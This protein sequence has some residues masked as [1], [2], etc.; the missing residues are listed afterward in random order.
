MTEQSSLPAKEYRCDN[1]CVTFQCEELQLVHE[2]AEA[3]P[4]ITYS[5]VGLEIAPTTG[6]LHLQ[7]Y[8]EFKN[9]MRYSTFASRFKNFKLGYF[10]ARF[11]TQAKAINYCKK[12]EKFHE[13]GEPKHQGERTDLA[14]IVDEIKNGVSEREL[15]LKYVNSFAKHMKWVQ[16]MI[17]LHGHPVAKAEYNLAECCM[18]LQVDDIPFENPQWNA[19]AVVIG[20]PGIGKTEFALA[21]F[22]N[23]LIVSHV[24]KLK[25]YDPTFHD[26]IVFDDMDFRHWPACSQKHLLDWTQDREINVKH[27]IAYIPKHTRKIFTCNYSEF[28]FDESNTAI[29]DR[30]YMVRTDIE[31]T[32]QRVK[33]KPQVG[34]S[35]EQKFA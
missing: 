31:L 27:A 6:K 1:A 32:S 18:H 10:K 35:C 21:H 24:D 12:D 15:S 33:L 8:F 2:M 7:C 14:D 28:P 5:C 30:I 29:M 13:S 25:E 23:P 16:R 17:Q 3:W 20:N 26:G 34:Y 19:S 9:T 4:Q 22:E 11:H